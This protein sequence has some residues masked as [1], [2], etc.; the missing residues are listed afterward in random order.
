MLELDMSTKFMENKDFDRVIEIDCTSSNQYSWEPKELYQEWKKPNGVGI[1][2]VDPEDLV[3]GFCVYN[4]NKE[5]YE[6]KHMV[7]DKMFQRLGIGRSLINRMK[8]KLNSNR[9][10]LGYNVP[11]DNL[12]FQLF[13]KNMGF[14]AKLIRNGDGDIF[15]FEY[16]KV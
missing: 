7:V 10:M 15:R 11:E 5:Y 13:L 3:L 1:V 9:C 14:K 4:L 8:D 2:A 6:I 12:I 16:E